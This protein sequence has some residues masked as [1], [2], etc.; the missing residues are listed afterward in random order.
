MGILTKNS[1]EKSNDPNNAQRSPPSGLTLMGAKYDFTK[2][3]MNPDF[4][5]IADN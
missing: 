2:S 4:V 5:E 1:S 3:A